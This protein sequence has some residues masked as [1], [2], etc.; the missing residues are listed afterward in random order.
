VP[1]AEDEV[2][3]DDEQLEEDDDDDQEDDEEEDVIIENDDY[4][5]RW[6]AFVSQVE[7]L[8]DPLLLSLFRQGRVVQV[9]A[10]TAALTV[11]FPK[12]FFFFN[13]WMLE[14]QPQWMSHLQSFFGAP[15]TLIPLFTA[16]ATVPHKKAAPS[17]DMHKAA[18]VTPA[19]KP[20]P[21]SSYPGSQ[22][23]QDTVGKQQLVRQKFET[24]FYQKRAARMPQAPLG[25]VVDISNTEQF[26]KAHMLLRYFPGTITEV[27]E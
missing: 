13:D 20:A 23:R 12:D 4:A 11:E 3:L 17:S 9:D 10:A 16:T 18:S 25:A 8:K 7:T 19:P 27:R 21:S 14:T 24:P 26:A 15:A 22:T 2:V 6:V 1:I 5:S